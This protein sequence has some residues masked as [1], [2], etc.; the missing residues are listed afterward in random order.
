MTPSRARLFTPVLI[1]GSIILLIN[2][3]LRASF[4]MFQILSLIHI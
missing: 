2:F 4:G 1:G 3:A